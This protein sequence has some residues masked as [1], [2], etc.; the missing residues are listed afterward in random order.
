MSDQ[1]LCEFPDNNPASG[2]IREILKNSKTIAVVGLSDK[3]ERDSNMVARYLK[4]HGYR[5]VP[6]NPARSEILGEK[7]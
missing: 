1:T 7:S 5:V 6:V 4:G 3:P 2:E